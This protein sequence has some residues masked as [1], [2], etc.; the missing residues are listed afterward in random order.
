MVALKHEHRGMPPRLLAEGADARMR[1]FRSADVFVVEAFRAAQSLRAVD[2]GILGDEIQRLLVEG[3][4]ALAAAASARVDRQGDEP[5][6]RDA[7]RCLEAARYALYLARRLGKL[8]LRRYRQLAILEDAAL[9]DMERLN[10]QAR[11][12]PHARAP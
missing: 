10:P 12:D 11:P 7:K 6:L 8:D 1:L 4:A 9:R 3:G 5:R 2:A